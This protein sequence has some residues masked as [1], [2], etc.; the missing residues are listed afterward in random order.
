MLKPS[1]LQSLSLLGQGPGTRVWH[2][3]DADGREL[4][5]KTFSLAEAPDWKAQELFEREAGVLQHLQH[6]RLPRLLA[7]G[8]EAGQSFLIYEFVPGESLAARLAAGWRPT[9]AEVLDLARQLL[10]ILG[11]LHGH[12]PPIIHR[13]IKPSNLILSPPAELYLIDFGAVTLKLKPEGGSTVAGTFGYMAP[14]QLSGRALPASDLY[15]LGVTLIQLLSGRAPGE[16]PSERLW[17][18]FEDY[19]AC[20]S[21]LKAWLRTLIHPVAEERCQSAVQ[22]LQSLDRALEAGTLATVDRRLVPPARPDLDPIQVHTSDKG[23]EILLPARPPAGL[24]LDSGG[25]RGFIGLYFSLICLYFVF[26]QIYLALG[27]HLSAIYVYASLSLALFVAASRHYH[28]RR[29]QGRRFSWLRLKDSGLTVDTYLDGI[30]Q[31]ELTLPWEQ[32]REIRHRPGRRGIQLRYATSRRR[33]LRRL[34]LGRS[35]SAEEQAWLA[36]LLLAEASDAA[37]NWKPE[38]PR[39]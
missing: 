24:G 7:Y 31:Q 16:L 14:E 25:A 2:G 4:L 32:I 1:E 28:Q 21:G 38:A 37:G 6:P 15:A 23:L 39:L 33:R 5:L 19:V 22:A 34:R 8:I 29:L 26:G 9:A 10:G 30:L 27:P 17:L 35:L 36:G 20:S 13:D 11:W 3:L 18:R 12:Q